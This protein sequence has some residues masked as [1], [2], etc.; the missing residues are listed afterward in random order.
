MNTTKAGLTRISAKKCILISVSVLVSTYIRAPGVWFVN[1]TCEDKANITVRR[2]GKKLELCDWVKE[3]PKKRCAKK[4]RI[5]IKKSDRR[6][7]KKRLKVSRKC[8]CTCAESNGLIDTDAC[9]IPNDIDFNN[10]LGGSSGTCDESV[11]PSSCAYEYVYTQNCNTGSIACEPK[12]TCNCIGTDWL[13]GEAQFQQCETPDPRDPRDPNQVVVESP[14]YIGE[15][16][17]PG[18]SLPLPEEVAS[19]SQ[20]GTNCRRSLRSL[21]TGEGCDDTE[22]EKVE[23]ELGVR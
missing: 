1:A 15:E 2:K 6:W 16:C 14:S 18:E 11:A 8:G 5:Y 7:I 21:S 22:E 23:M 17:T 19:E 10:S 9:P 20:E 13:C 4:L 3:K 12:F